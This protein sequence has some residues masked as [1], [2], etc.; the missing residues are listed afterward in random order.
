MPNENKYIVELRNITKKYP[1]VVALDNVSIGFK[2]GEVHAIMGENGAG[3]STMIK[4]ISGALTPTSGEVLIDGVAY[5]HL[6]PGKS[7]ELGIEVIYQEINAFTTLTVMENIY[8]G[9]LPGKNGVVDKKQLKKQTAELFK[10][11]EFSIS[12]TDVMEN[13]TAGYIQMVQK[14]IWNIC[15]CWP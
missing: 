3:K 15:T 14:S 12:P 1:G 5:Q 13:M 2:P 11:M 8:M 4:A 10:E 6:T 9:S 7:R